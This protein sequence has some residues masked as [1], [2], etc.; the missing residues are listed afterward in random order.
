MINKIIFLDV[1]SNNS[2]AVNNGDCDQLCNVTSNNTSY[3]SCFE[4]YRL[5]SDG[6]SCTGECYMT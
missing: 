3:C 2:C 4:G 1:Q 5:S 6:K